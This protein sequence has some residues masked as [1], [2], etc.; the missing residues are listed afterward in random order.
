MTPA[1]QRSAI[2]AVLILLAGV[3]AA[4]DSSSTGTETETDASVVG[5]WKGTVLVT[6]G[7]QNAYPQIL[8]LSQTGTAVTGTAD[9]D[10]PDPDD[11]G[12]LTGSVSGSTFTFHI[13]YK[14]TPGIDDCGNYPVDGSAKIDG[15]KMTVT[16][17]TA[18]ECEGD[19]H[20][21]HSTLVNLT[22]TGGT[23]TK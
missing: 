8:K 19:G 1:R 23:L 4:C 22:L 20:G 14:S 3:A 21:G 16:G 7:D 13:K 15:N 9:Y 11:V 12:T 2:S 17:G 6:G 18:F 10:P 5:T